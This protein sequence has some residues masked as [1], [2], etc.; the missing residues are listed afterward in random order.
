M[1]YLTCPITDKI[2]VDQESA[3]FDEKENTDRDGAY[4]AATVGECACS[5]YD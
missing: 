4:R 1:P 5:I 3:F 2:D